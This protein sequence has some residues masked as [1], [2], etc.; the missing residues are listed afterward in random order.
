MVRE[1]CPRLLI[2]REQVGEGLFP[3]EGLN[4]GESNY[5]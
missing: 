1:D 4:F 3:E 2:N 5:R